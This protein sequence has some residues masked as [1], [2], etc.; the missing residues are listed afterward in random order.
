MKTRTSKS[1]K[2]AQSNADKSIPSLVLGQ[3]PL[4]LLLLPR[5][6]GPDAR[7]CTLAHPS[8]FKPT[9]YYCCPKSGLHEFRKIAAPKKSCRSWLLGPKAAEKSDQLVAEALSESVDGTSNRPMAPPQGYTIKDPEIFIAT[10]IDAL[11]FILPSLYGQI[12]RNAKGRFLSLDDL[13]DNAFDKSKHRKY[14]LEHGNLRQAVEA[15]MAVVCD[16]VD[17]G[18]EKMYRLNMN[19]LVLEL[20]AKAKRMSSNGL[21][22]SMEAKF[23]DKALDVPMMSLK[24][25]SSS[26]SQATTEVATS[27]DSQPTTAGESQ[28]STDTGES[29]DTQ[30]SV[31]TDITVPDQPPPI[32]MPE[33]I[34]DLL[35]L[36]TALSFMLSSCL[37]PSLASSVQTVLSSTSSPVDFKLL[38]SHLT[39]LTALRTEALASRSL[40]NISRKRNMGDSD[41]AAEVKAEKRR[42]KE[43]EE[44]RQKIGLTK[45]VRDLKKADITGMKKMSDFFGKKPA[46]AKK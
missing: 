38:D 44:K 31:Q 7:I 13:L 11:F 24:R 30:L 41:E 37:S 46:Q 19:K 22:T 23:V 20:V 39:H 16:N 28:P 3:D 15:R 17:A 4:R 40:S 9:R 26:M 14:I 18:D 6:A 33:N 32:T 27:T 10:P 25:E 5:S 29:M 21:P 43:D 34:K 35:R 45:G 1:A 8:T 36:R 2:P 42:K 12:S